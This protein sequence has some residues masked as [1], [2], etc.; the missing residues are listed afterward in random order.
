MGSRVV[1][2]E[3]TEMIVQDW[4]DAD[5]EGAPEFPTLPDLMHF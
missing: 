4:L 1:G 5:Y 3:L 2:E